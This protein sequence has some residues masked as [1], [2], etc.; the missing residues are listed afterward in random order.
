MESQKMQTSLVWRF[1]AKHPRKLD[2]SIMK[3]WPSCQTYMFRLC[4]SNH[5]RKC[6][7]KQRKM[8]SEQCRSNRTHKKSS[9][10]EVVNCPDNAVCLNSGSGGRGVGQVYPQSRQCRLSC[11]YGPR[12]FVEVWAKNGLE[13]KGYGK[14]TTS[15][16]KIHVDSV[17]WIKE[18]CHQLQ[19]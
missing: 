10:Y 7:A 14:S 8:F 16:F 17:E 18:W 4:N 5:Q 12:L 13:P 11:G 9:L 3:L 2:D 19:V 1:L 15:T 6:K